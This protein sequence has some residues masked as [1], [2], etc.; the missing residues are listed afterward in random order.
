MLSSAKEGRSRLVFL[1]AWALPSQRGT[2]PPVQCDSGPLP[3]LHAYHSLIN[4]FY[5]TGSYLILPV[6]PHICFQLLLGRRHS[7]RWGDVRTSTEQSVRNER[8]WI[9]FPASA[10]PR[11]SPPFPESHLPGLH[12]H[13]SS[14][15]EVLVVPSGT[16]QFLIQSLH[17]L[18][19][20]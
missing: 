8:Y 15:R 10:I 14:L 20:I 6:P 17:Y 19:I 5:H 18:Y 12:I 9:C 1:H 7:R 16:C 2:A 4:Y 11:T 13:Y 3:R